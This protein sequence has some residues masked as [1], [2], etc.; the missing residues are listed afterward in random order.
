MRAIVAEQIEKCRAMGEFDVVDDLANPLTAILTL[1]FAG[2][3]VEDWEI[4]LRPVHQQAY[5]DRLSP[6][7]ERVLADAGS[8]REH[9]RRF[10]AQR[11]EQPADDLTSLLL[12]AEIDGVPL[13]EEE[14]VD[15]LWTFMGGGFDTTSGAIAYIM[16]DLT[17][18]PERRRQLMDDPQLLPTAIEEYVRHF[19]P[20]TSVARTVTQPV[21]VADEELQPGDR[22][23]LCWGAANHDPDKFED[24][25]SIQL[26][27]SPNR[28]LGWGDG[29]HRCVGTRFARTEMRIF[30]EE[31]LQRMPHFAVDAKQAVEF[32]SVALVAGFVKLP[33]VAQ[34]AAAGR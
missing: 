32:P 3:P 14:I 24:P 28:H 22:V 27:R 7:F 4:Y 15:Y 12:A 11:R 1:D 10:I 23:L 29:V 17:E 31:L 30:F 34:A 2:M 6:E 8:G 13:S 18:H 19:S 33:A 25:D 9:T 20:S 16:I 21:S 26:D 5:V